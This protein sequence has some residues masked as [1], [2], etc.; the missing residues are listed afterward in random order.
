MLEETVPNV[1]HGPKMGQKNDSA[2]V[3]IVFPF[4]PL[5]YCPIIKPMGHES[6]STPQARLLIYMTHMIWSF[7]QA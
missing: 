3:P 1:G 4:I 7:R 2:C 6:I 5:V